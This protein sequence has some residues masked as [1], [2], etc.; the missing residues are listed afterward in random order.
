MTGQQEMALNCARE[1]FPKFGI[2]VNFFTE[3]VVMHWNREVVGSLCLK[4]F[5]RG[6]ALLWGIWFRSKHIG[7]G[8]TTGLDCL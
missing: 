8:L 6:V 3:K 2:R 7:A 4:V 1:A 5:K